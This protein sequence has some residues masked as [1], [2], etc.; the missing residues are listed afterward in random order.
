MKAEREA[1]IK[2][3]REAKIK[4]E[5]EAQRKRSAAAAKKSMLVFV[6]WFLV[7]LYFFTH[8]HLLILSVIRLFR[9]V[10][11][12]FPRF[13]GQTSRLLICLLCVLVGI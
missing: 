2:A 8:Q 3:E 13:V 7:R 4:A 11:A 12:L 6:F 9:H 5:Q 10:V 1:K